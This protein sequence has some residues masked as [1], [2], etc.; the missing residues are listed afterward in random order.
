MSQMPSLSELQK[1]VVNRDGWEVI[2]QGLFDSNAYPAA[3]ATQLN[4]FAN[5]IGQGT[6][7]GGGAKTASDTNM[8]LA[9]QLPAMQGFLVEAVEILF[10]PTTPTVAAQ[11]PAAFGAQAIAQVVND[12]YIFRRSGNLNFLVGSKP[13]LQDGPMMKFPASADFQVNAALSDVSTAGASFQSRIAYGKAVGRTYSLGGAPIYLTANQNFNLSLNW[14]EGL[15][16]ITNPAWVKVT[17]QG[18]LYRRSQ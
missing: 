11:M 17:L 4:F 2:R 10:L 5:P 16:A 18:L 1:Y 7:L 3:G 14:P 9:G 6:G 15:Q 8:N 13:Y 12:A